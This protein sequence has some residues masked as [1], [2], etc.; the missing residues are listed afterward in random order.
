MKM[1]LKKLAFA[2]MLTALATSLCVGAL[3]ETEGAGD[4]PAVAA[5]EPTAAPAA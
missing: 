5:A 4:V 1:L 2:M 3:A